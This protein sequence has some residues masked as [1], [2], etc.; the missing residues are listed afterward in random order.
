MT[1]LLAITVRFLILTQWL[2]QQ[3]TSLPQQDIS[4]VLDMASDA[5]DDQYVNCTEEMDKKAPQLLEK[6]LQVNKIFKNEWEKAQIK[7]KKIKNKIDSSKQLNDFQGTAVVA[8]TGDISIEFN[9]AIR[10]FGQNSREFQFKAFHYYLTRALQLLY[11]GGCHTVYRGAQKKFIYSGKGNVRFGQFA[12]S[13]T[14]LKEAEKFLQETRGTLRGTL[15][16]IH[17]C[18]GVD[19]QA[20]SYYPDEKEVLIPGYEVFQQVTEL[21]KSKTYSRFSLKS[22]GK[23]KSKYNCFY[24]SGVRQSPAFRLLLPSLLALQLLLAEL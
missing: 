19:I 15:F 1:S 11:K 22:L 20:F 12:S 23:L 7:W 21:S 14:S 17:T 10:T 6:E 13:S 8:Y 4:A 24:T 9:E 2:A 18:L 5:F 16:S 3:V